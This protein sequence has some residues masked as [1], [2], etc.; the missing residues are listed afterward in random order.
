M[1]D[2]YFQSISVF[3]TS[4]PFSREAEEQLTERGKKQKEKKFCELS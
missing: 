3:F 4:L 1:I 2:F